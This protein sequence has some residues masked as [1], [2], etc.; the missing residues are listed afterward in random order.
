LGYQIFGQYHPAAPKGSRCDANACALC[1]VPDPTANGASLMVGA[2]T[3]SAE[4]RSWTGQCRP[5]ISVCANAARLGARK[6]AS[7]VRCQKIT[8]LS[9]S[10]RRMQRRHAI[11]G[12]V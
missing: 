10:W 4:F 1:S 5:S 12:S 3:G 2:P 6:E 7:P 8:P 11:H 9:R